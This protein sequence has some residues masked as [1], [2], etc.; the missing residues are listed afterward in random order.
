MNLK[1]TSWLTEET[2]QTARDIEGLLGHADGDEGRKALQV[3]GLE[4]IVLVI[5][6]KAVIGVFS[7]FAG[8]LLYDKWKQARTRKQLDEVA[9]QLSRRV[10][11][12]LSAGL[13]DEN[14]IRNDVTNTLTLE[15]LTKEQAEKVCDL[16]FERVHARIG[17]L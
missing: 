8:R 2:N 12:E 16:T 14:V 1:E 11:T 3:T 7:G 13:V 15:G 10:V 5:A 9:A 4:P 6:A 17:R